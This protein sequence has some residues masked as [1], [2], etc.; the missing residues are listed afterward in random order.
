MASFLKN[1]AWSRIAGH[2]RR[3]AQAL[4][5]LATLWFGWRLAGSLWLVTGQDHAD[6]PRPVAESGPAVA[7]PEIDT[8]LLAGFSLF[9]TPAAPS[10]AA[11]NATQETSLQLRLDGVFAGSDPRRSGAIITDQAQ[12]VGKLY[13]VGQAVAGGATLESVYADRVILS[14]NGNREVL[15]FVRTNLLGGDPPPAAGASAAGQSGKAREML[16]SAIERL[17]SEPGAYLSEMGLVAGGEGYEITD[18]APAN[19]RRSLGLKAGDR[20]LRLNGQPLGNPQLDRQLLE[21][22]KQSGHV[23]VDLRR[24]SQNLTIEQNF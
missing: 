13:A 4:M 6:L 10:G 18:G 11:E 24:G 21:Q 3:M 8:S 7:Q 19:I 14:R 20:I 1:P 22:V 2:N 17:G 23:R 9:K 5:L 12:G 16:S 15:R